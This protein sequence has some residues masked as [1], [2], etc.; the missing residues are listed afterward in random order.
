M[1]VYNGMPYLPAAVQSVLSQTWRD[2]RLVVVDDGSTDQSVP[3]L[4]SVNDQRLEIMLVET[5]GGQ[6]AARNIA[7][8][9]CCTEYVAFADADDVS[10]PERMQRQIDFLNA[11]PRVGM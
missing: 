3:Y 5:R 2:L 7:L 4:R 9:N 10:K 11:N 8:R 1:P 6:G